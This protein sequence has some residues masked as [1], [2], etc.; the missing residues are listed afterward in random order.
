MSTLSRFHTGNPLI[1]GGTSWYLADLGE[2][3]GKQELYT[4]QAPQRLKTLRE[5]ALIESTVSSN[6]MEGVEVE[7]ARVRDV[8]LAAKPMFR[9][10]DEE[11]IRG[12]REALTEIHE[13]AALG[14]SELPRVRATGRRHPGTARRQDRD[15]ACSSGADAPRVHAGSNEAGL[16]GRQ[17]R[18]GAPCADGAEGPKGRVHRAGSGCEVEQEGVTTSKAGKE[19]GN[20]TALR[21]PASRTVILGWLSAH[22]RES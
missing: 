22:R 14:V 2:F 4:R 7:A 1:P 10:R 20:N 11:E 9:D 17:S 5:H 6:R 15:G 13:G 18:D 16:P 19:K 8:L 3:R 12:Y 21:L